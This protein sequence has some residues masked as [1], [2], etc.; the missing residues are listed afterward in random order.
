MF[1]EDWGTSPH[2]ARTTVHGPSKTILLALLSSSPSYHHRYLVDC[3]PASFM[4]QVIANTPRRFDDGR[5]LAS[6]RCSARPPR[7]GSCPC[8][9]TRTLRRRRP[10]SQAL[11]APGFELGLRRALPKICHCCSAGRVA[12]TSKA[13]CT[14]SNWPVRPCSVTAICSEPCCMSL[15]SWRVD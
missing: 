12:Q 1:L 8:S 6:R 15:L 4:N 14:F 3:T 13:R 7:F 2:C 10:P 9:S 11:E 5:L